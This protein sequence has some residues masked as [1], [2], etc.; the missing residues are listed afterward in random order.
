MGICVN[1]L[2]SRFL[3]PQTLIAH[4][5]IRFSKILPNNPVHKLCRQFPDQAPPAS[6]GGQSTNPP[7]LSISFKDLCLCRGRQV[8]TLHG[9]TGVNTPKQGVKTHEEF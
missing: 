2:I 7:P 6:L 4:P 9:V 3:P 8:T 1:V 5:C